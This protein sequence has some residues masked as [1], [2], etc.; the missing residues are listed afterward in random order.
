[1]DKGKYEKVIFQLDE[2]IRHL[3]VDSKDVKPDRLDHWIE[4]WDKIET[5]NQEVYDSIY[6]FE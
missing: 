5:D 6:T 2:L 4:Y 1:M 3:L